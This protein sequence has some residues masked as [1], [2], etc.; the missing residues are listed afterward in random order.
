MTKD[1]ALSKNHVPLVVMAGILLTGAAPAF[2]FDYQIHGFATQGFILSDG[3]NLFGDST[4]GSFEYFEAGVS[5]AVQLRPDLLISAQGVVRDA[6]ATDTGK[7]RLDY[8]LL[9]YRAYSGTESGVGLRLG[10]VKNPF[11]LFN[12]TRDVVFTRPGILMPTS[13]YNDNLGERS[14]LFS[15]NGAQLYGNR[16]LGSHDISFVGT[17]ARNRKFSDSEKRLVLGGEL[18]GFDF[19]LKLKNFWNARVMDELDGGR[20][21]FALSHTDTDLVVNTDPSFATFGRLGV[22][23][24]VLS[25]QFNAE[26]FSLTSEYIL[27]SAKSD[28]TFGGQTQASTDRLDGGYIQADYR[29]NPQWAAMLRYDAYFS[30]RNNRSGSNCGNR[31][32]CFALDATAGVSWRYDE[33]WG[34]WGEYHYIDGIATLQPLDNEGRTPVNHWSV[35]LLMAGYHF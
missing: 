4:H 21:R 35:F 3:N 22:T 16:L 29:F 32:D 23:L 7:P 28:F 13:I 33:H 14:I 11:G 25:A 27:Y 24:D 17:V 2:A 19:D 1:V 31:Y 5:A 26:T 15:S 34:V 18:P 6:G 10:K 20:W 30:D 9:D 12:D 8:A